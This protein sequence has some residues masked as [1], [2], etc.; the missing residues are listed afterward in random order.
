MRSF[1]KPFLLLFFIGIISNAFSQ[2]ALAVSKN[3]NGSSVK[4]SLQL[5]S[6][7]DD[8]CAKA[9]ADLE[10]QGLKN[11]FVLKSTEN[12]GHNLS[13]GF[14]VLIISSRKSPGGKFFISYGLGG[15]SISKEEAINNAVIHLK[16]H[17]WGYENNYAYAIEKE[18]RIENFYPKEEDKK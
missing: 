14:Y 8:A 13:T 9:Q 4:Y 1:L 15:S 12:T 7:L 18:G 17:D 16:E 2:I 6:T 11:V 10:S 5:G 3:D